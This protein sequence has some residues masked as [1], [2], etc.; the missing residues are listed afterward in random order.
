MVEAVVKFSGVTPDQLYSSGLDEEVIK[1]LAEHFDVGASNAEIVSVEEEEP[2]FLIVT[3]LIT[4]TG[5]ADVGS[6]VE[7]MGWQDDMA[8]DMESFLQNTTSHYWSYEEG[9]NNAR[10][11]SSSIRTDSVLRS[12]P[13]IGWIPRETNREAW[14]QIDLLENV[15]V[16]GIVTQASGRWRPMGVTSYKVQYSSDGDIFVDLPD[17][18]SGPTVD[19]QKYHWKQS[20]H[21]KFEA[22][23]PYVVTARYFRLLPYTWGTRTFPVSRNKGGTGRPGLRADVLLYIKADASFVGLTA[24]IKKPDEVSPA[25]T[26]YALLLN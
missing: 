5:T 26:F 6:I 25:L 11:F 3:V 8:S 1:L 9:S 18:L 13:S 22:L 2:S 15:Q 7:E 17:L 14:M 19:Y 20:K 21:E 24:E 4:T 12:T 16:A 23:F 10:T